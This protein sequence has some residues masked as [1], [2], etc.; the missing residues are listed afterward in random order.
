MHC[1]VFVLMLT[2]VLYC[3]CLDDDSSLVLCLPW[4]WQQSC[5]VF[6]LMLTAVLCCVYLDVDSSLVFVLM[7]TAVLCCVYLDVD[8]SLVFVLMLTA[9]LCCVYLDVDSSLVFVLMLTAVLCRGHKLRARTPR[10]V[11]WGPFCK[12]W[13]TWSMLGY[14][15]QRRCWRNAATSVYFKWHECYQRDCK[16]TAVV[17]SKAVTWYLRGTWV[18]WLVFGL[19]CKGVGSDMLYYIIFKSHD[20]CM[21]V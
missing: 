20:I 10:W 6:V 8:S 19:L 14:Q 1:Y 9:V 17:V 13:R 18:L 7:L 11:C 21:W 2:A 4:C 15:L 16:N 3:V 12:V 5:V